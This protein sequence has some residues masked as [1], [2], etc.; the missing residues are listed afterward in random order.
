[1][2]TAG[3]RMAID[4]LVSPESYT[5]INLRKRVEIWIQQPM[6]KSRKLGARALYTTVACIERFQYVIAAINDGAHM[7]LD[8]PSRAFQT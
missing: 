5:T 2:A 6:P 3:G 1:M 7:S 4:P 8:P